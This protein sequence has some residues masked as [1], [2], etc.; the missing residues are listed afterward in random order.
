MSSSRK[1]RTTLK[2]DNEMARWWPKF[3]FSNGWHHLGCPQGIQIGPVFTRLKRS[4]LYPTL[5]ENW[6]QIPKKLRTKCRKSNVPQWM[7]LC[8]LRFFSNKNLPTDS[9]R[10]CFIFPSIS[11]ASSFSCKVQSSNFASGLMI[12]STNCRCPHCIFLGFWM[13]MA[14]ELKMTETHESALRERALRSPSNWWQ[15]GLSS[16]ALSIGDAAFNWQKDLHNHSITVSSHDFSLGFH[17]SNESPKTRCQVCISLL[18]MK[19]QK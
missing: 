16:L 5:V 17:T 1:L 19:P 18:S 6:V 15:F 3:S 4:N 8:L 12:W 11:G 7:N 13:S 2:S 14:G 9:R 10:K